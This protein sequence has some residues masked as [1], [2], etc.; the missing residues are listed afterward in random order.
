MSQGHGNFSQNPMS[1][2]HGNFNQNPMS[3]G[4]KD[5]PAKSFGPR[6]QRISEKF[7]GKYVPGTQKKF[8][9]AASR[10]IYTK[11]FFPPE[12]LCPWD[13]EKK[14]PPVIYTKNF[15]R[16]RRGVLSTHK[17]KS[18]CGEPYYLL[19]VFIFRFLFSFIFYIFLW[20]CLLLRV[21]CAKLS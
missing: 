17:K 14:F 21:L 11:N 12:N 15:F 9:P 5:F 8:P 19:L 4:P 7:P 16:L 20:F 3:Q 1:Q 10:F 2:G 6:D 13:I 18:V